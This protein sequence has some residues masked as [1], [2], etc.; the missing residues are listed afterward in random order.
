MWDWRETTADWLWDEEVYPFLLSLPW[1]ETTI[2]ID[3]NQWI[4][5][6]ERDDEEIIYDNNYE[7]ITLDL[8]P[9]C[10]WILLGKF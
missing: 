3:N 5:F 9:Y 4:S 2:S 10:T 8:Y 1:Q 6:E 7:E